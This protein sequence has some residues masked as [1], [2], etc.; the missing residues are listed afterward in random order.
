MSLAVAALFP[1]SAGKH[2]KDA[3]SEY[4]LNSVTITSYAHYHSDVTYC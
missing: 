3:M 4:T 2:Y 1:Q